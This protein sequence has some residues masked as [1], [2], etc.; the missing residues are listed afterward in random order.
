MKSVIRDCDGCGKED[1]IDCNS[2]LCQT[3]LKKC[4]DEIHNTTQKGGDK[5]HE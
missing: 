3:C 4:E 2:G 5:N 1:S